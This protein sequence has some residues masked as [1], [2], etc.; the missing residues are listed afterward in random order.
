MLAD[1]IKGGFWGKLEGIKQE[2]IMKK[3]FTLSI[4]L[5][6][7]GCAA[8][9]APPTISSQNIMGNV[10]AS[11]SDIL[12]ATKGIL[13][14]DGYQILSSDE[15]SGTISTSSKRMKLNATQCDCGTTMGLPYIKDNRTFT[16]VALGILIS[17]NKISIKANITGEYLKGDATQ[18]VNM[19]CVSTGDIENKLI[20][21]I[22]NQLR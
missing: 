18:G 20:E 15:S 17:E 5:L 19:T 16:D 21:K 10:Q 3:L 9:Y 6:F 2:A 14:M 1:W 22:K 8:T 11:K 4:I 7:I 13:V 12:N